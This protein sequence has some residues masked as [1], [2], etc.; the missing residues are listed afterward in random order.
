MSTTIRQAN[1]TSGVAGPCYESRALGRESRVLTRDQ[2]L[3]TRDQCPVLGI[4]EKCFWVAKSWL[5]LGLRWSGGFR[6]VCL[7]RF[8]G[9]S[10]T[11]T[12]L[13]GPFG[14][15]S[16]FGWGTHLGTTLE[17]ERQTC[18]RVCPSRE[19]FGSSGR[20]AQVWSTPSGVDRVVPSG[21]ANSRERET[22]PGNRE[23]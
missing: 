14:K 21:T 12:S 10:E 7:C 15:L 9:D 6:Y 17:R 23:C 5:A 3:T 16:G 11:A 19:T 8:G 18:K 13:K 1:D 4:R 22:L 2:Q 20:T